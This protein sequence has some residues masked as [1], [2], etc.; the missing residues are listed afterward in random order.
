MGKALIFDGNSILNRAF[1]GVRP[2][3]APDG[4]P[5]NALFGFVGMINKAFSQIGGADY[6]AIAFDLKEKTFRHIACE[7]YKATRKP[8]PEELALQLPF[9]KQIATALGIK[10]LSIAG[11]EADDILGTLSAEFTKGG[12]KTYIVTGDRDSF[13]LVNESVTVLLASNEDTKVTTP[14]EIMEKYGCEPRRLIDI[15]ALMG[16]S[17]DNIAGVPGIGEKG[18]IKLISEYGTL[19]NIYEHAEEIAG[20]VGKK[21]REGKESAYTSRFLAEIKLDVPL[22]CDIE[23]CAFKGNN[24][25][26]LRELYIR[27]GFKQFLDRL[28]DAAPDFQQETEFLPFSELG[29]VTAETLYINAAE[30]ELHIFAKGKC[31]KGGIDEGI[32][33]AADCERAVCWSSKEILHIAKRTG[34]D[35]KA[36]EDVSLMAYVCSPADNGVSFGKVALDNVG[37]NANEVSVSLLPQ[38]YDKLNEKLTP[39]LNNL[40]REW[41]LPLAEL[42]CRMEIN[43]FPVDKQAL[44]IFSDSLSQSIAEEENAIYALA[45]EEFNINSPKQLGNILF[46]KLML[47]HYR[48]TKSGY[49]T[50]RET[51]E[52][53][54]PY[55]PIIGL[56]L[57]YREDTKL[58]NTYCDGM[59]KQITPEGRIHTTFKQ[60]QTLTG[61]L[62]S[63]EPNLQNIPVR[64]DK[65]R[66]LRKFFV[67]EKG[68]I[69]IDADYSQIELRVL[70]HVSDDEV[71]INAFKNGEDIHTV[72]ASQVFGVPNEQ[73][74]S[75]MRKRAKAVNFGIIY[76]IGDYSLSQDLKIPR[77]TAAEYIENYLAKYAGVRDYLQNAKDFARENGY[78]QSFFGRRRYIPEL[79]AS[80]KITQA[81]GERVAMNM[82][83]QGAAA[84]LIKIAMLRTDRMLKEAGLKAK[85]ILQIHDELIVDSPIEEAD[86]A[87][88][89][90]RI[91]MQEAADLKVP[92]A[93]DIGRGQSWFDAKD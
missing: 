31:F 28:G 57:E 19:D 11:Y 93:V 14:K 90:L 15:K 71:L 16:D 21:L 7:S 70:A 85:L 26:E 33:I 61:R 52:K 58:K 43:G 59:G 3:N 89:I 5:T 63:A 41:E 84:D 13:Q 32:R 55:H 6:A 4:L 79:S 86:K 60:T 44:E 53:L 1:Y 88:E 47:P 38:I 54:E 78:A 69:L 25:S 62:S 91:A 40:Y 51:L 76:G 80:N 74:T 81:F 27:L 39:A 65:G 83:I 50:D 42:L 37:V 82:P 24:V 34:V 49:S 20:S 22:A 30:E 48:K 17:S 35:F 23:D 72:T 77:K 12:H 2:L 75:E 10:V 8:M 45:G 73:V 64:S 87:E 67:A 68:H 46:E 9:S 92:L 29:D 36:L 56:I 66:E 18:A